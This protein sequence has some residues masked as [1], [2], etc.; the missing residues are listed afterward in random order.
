M[1]RY[2]F[3]A[4]HFPVL[5][6]IATFEIQRYLFSAYH[7]SILFQATTF[8]IQRLKCKVTCFPRPIFP[9][10]FKNKSS[11]TNRNV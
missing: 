8:E 9:Y 3:S 1:Q 5:F 4:Y 2:L 10:F 6:Q 11:F 7:F